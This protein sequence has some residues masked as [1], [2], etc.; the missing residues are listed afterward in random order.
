[1]SLSDVQ[2][3]VR[4]GRR[5]SFIWHCLHH[6]SRQQRSDGEV[7]QVAHRKPGERR[8]CKMTVEANVQH[9]KKEKGGGSK[10]RLFSGACFSLTW[11]AEWPL[12]PGRSRWNASSRASHSCQSFSQ[13]CNAMWGCISCQTPAEGREAEEISGNCGCTRTAPTT[14]LEHLFDESGDILL[15]VELVHRLHG[16]VNCVLLHVF[17][18]VYI[19]YHCLLLRH[20]GVIHCTGEERN[21]FF[22]HIVPV[23]ST[24]GETHPSS[25]T[26]C[27][28][29]ITH[30]L[31]EGVYFLHFYF[32]LN[33][34]IW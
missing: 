1:M 18:H 9:G 32:F 16:K 19:L 10:N 7:L 5:T 34:A 6:Q 22:P 3:Q 8:V 11:T 31:L 23:G 24:S 30:W 33:N 29:V 17:G 14:D 2:M 26:T 28:G 12:D 4:A 15:D 21:T 25:S 20:V 27:T 13:L